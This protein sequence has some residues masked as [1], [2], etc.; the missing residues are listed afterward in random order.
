MRGD[1]LAQHPLWPRV[2]HRVALVGEH[3]G[4]P[5]LVLERCASFT[6]QVAMDVSVAS[7]D[8]VA[9]SQLMG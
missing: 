7:V 8:D 4:V 3:K 9:S 2:V 6:S 1:V 5:V